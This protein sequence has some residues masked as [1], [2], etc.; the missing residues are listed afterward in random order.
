M[1][2]LILNKTKKC[3]EYISKNDAS[4]I[5]I[6][7]GEQIKAFKNQPLYFYRFIEDE[8]CYKLISRQ[9]IIDN[10]IVTAYDTV[11]FVKK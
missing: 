4:I 7:D 11:I 2:Y 8:I 10:Q 6:V 3:G 5:G 1:K 9:E